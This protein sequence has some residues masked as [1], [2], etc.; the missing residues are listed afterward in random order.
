IPYLS[1]KYVKHAQWMRGTRMIIKDALTPYS[2]VILTPFYVLLDINNITYC[3]NSIFF[4]NV[5]LK[6]ELLR[7]ICIALFKFNVGF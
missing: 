6:L 1:Q 4:D 7:I 2:Y 3:Q 5:D